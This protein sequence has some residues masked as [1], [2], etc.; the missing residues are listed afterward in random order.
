MSPNLKQKLRACFK[1]L[2]PQCNIKITLKSTYRLSTLFHFKDII[3]KELHSHIVYNVLCG[4]CNVTNYGK[5]DGH[6][7]VRSSEHIRIYLTGKRVECKP[8]TVS[9]HLYCITMTTI[10]T[11][12]LSYIWLINQFVRL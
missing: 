2:L 12:S 5:T 4:N 1:N 9:D 11:T 8:S 7:N 3:P 10:L 6:L